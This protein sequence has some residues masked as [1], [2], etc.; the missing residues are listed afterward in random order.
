M[1][2]INVYF[3]LLALTINML[4]KMQLIMSNFVKIAHS[5]VMDVNYKNLEQETNPILIS[6]VQLVSLEDKEMLKDFA[7]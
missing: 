2:I 3:Q 6:H 4:G 7:K 5:V 1:L